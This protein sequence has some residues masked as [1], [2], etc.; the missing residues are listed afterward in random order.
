MDKW[1]G[2]RDRHGKSCRVNGQAGPGEIYPGLPFASPMVRWQIPVYVRAVDMSRIPFPYKHMDIKDLDTAS[3][4]TR[5]PG[6]PFPI[7]CLS[8]IDKKRTVQKP[9]TG[10][11]MSWLISWRPGAS[12]KNLWT[13]PLTAIKKTC[14]GHM[15]VYPESGQQVTNFHFEIAA[16]L[17]G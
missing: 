15:A 14:H 10:P 8:S 9:G 6:L 3:F 4:I 7:N 11:L 12:G 5:Q 2:K 17:A 13:G 16:D 1:A